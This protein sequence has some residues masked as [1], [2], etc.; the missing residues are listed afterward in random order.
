[1]IDKNIQFKKALDRMENTH[2]NLFITGRA[3]TGKSTL[4]TY[5]RHH[6]K[7]KIVVL[8]PT[9]VAAVNVGGQTIHS[10]F[11]FTPETTPDTVKNPRGDDEQKKIYRELDAIVIDEISMVRADLFDCIDI[12]LRK[13][14][15]DKRKP[16]GGVQMILIGD[17][18][19]LP[20][21]VTRG[22]QQFF[23]E[24]YDSSYFFAAHV[25]GG[26]KQKKML[27]EEIFELEI[28]ELEKM[29]RQTDE[30][31]IS[32][33][34]AVRDTTLTMAQLQILNRRCVDEDFDHSTYEG[35]WV[36]T[37][38]A[39]AS[40][41]N[42]GQLQA[43]EEKERV[44]TGRVEHKFDRGAF[45]TD[46]ELKLKIGARVMV[47]H[48]DPWGKWHNGSMGVVKSFSKVEGEDEMIE[49]SLDSGDDV[50]IGMYTW[51]MYR[52]YFD[53][54]TKQVESETIGSFIQ[55]PLKLAWAV[56]IHKAQ[57]KTFD[58]VLLDIGSGTFVSGQVYVALSRCTTFE[59]LH[60]RRP[61]KRE[62]VWTDPAVHAFVTKSK[63]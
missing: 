27:E 53:P 13:A 18:Y 37:T 56:T 30:E 41:V 49:V 10:F 43:L 47:L 57:G 20:P 35:V 21:V 45:P 28:I 46:A 39:L 55:Y 6:T 40:A 17:L 60:L 8:A 25:C 9:G 7:K 61:L 12:F 16:F 54:S 3:G 14:G 59:G 58:R 11:G 34:N 4:L 36:T 38:N 51:D 44:F 22:E 50:L 24:R 1:M 29:Y 2:T 63:S 62:H 48:N 19:Q 31:F 23:S 32:L 26:N 52:F 15:K 33:L 5:F 42:Q